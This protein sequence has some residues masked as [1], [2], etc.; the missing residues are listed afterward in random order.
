MDLRIQREKPFADSKLIFFTD[1]NP[2]LKKIDPYMWRPVFSTVFRELLRLQNLEHERNFWCPSA[3]KYIFETRPVMVK[4]NIGLL[5]HFREIWSHDNS[6][7][8]NSKRRKRVH[9]F[10][11]IAKWQTNSVS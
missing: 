10:K 2:R 6:Q 4:D 3:D 1:G 9:Q 11:K 5:K 8:S 7:M